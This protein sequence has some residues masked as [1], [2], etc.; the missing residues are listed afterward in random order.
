V[1]ILFLVV[2]VLGLATVAWMVRTV[3]RERRAHQ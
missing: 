1:T 2:F 3:L